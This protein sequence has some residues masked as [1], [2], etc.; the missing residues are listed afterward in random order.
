MS[1]LKDIKIVLVDDHKL[2]R[3]GL[4]N[5]I[6]Q[7]SN[8]HIIGEAS[9]GR[10]AIKICP[11]LLPNVVVMDVAMPGLNGVEATRQIHKN[12]PEIKII[13]LSMHSSKQF[14][15]SMF[16]AG[17]FAYLLKDG[18]SD[19]LITAICTVMQ[20]KKYLSNDINQEFLSVLKEPK[21]IEKTQLSSRE[22][23]VLQLIAEGRSSKEIGEILF[24][25]PKT[26]DVHRNNIMK[27]LDLFTIPELTKYAIQEGL[28]SLGI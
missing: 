22:K 27:K 16:K 12:N 28:T 21:G 24:L 3:D 11:K 7:R 1:Y 2:L 17:A 14:I 4:R 25:S 13:G 23:E 6:E 5:I 18:D 15:Q 26:V 10:E 9:D 20:N 8:M 19:E